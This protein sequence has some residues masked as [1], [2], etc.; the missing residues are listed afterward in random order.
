VTATVTQLKLHWP[1]REQHPSVRVNDPDTCVEPSEVRMSSG[2]LKAL[3][4]HYLH[5][6]GLT[7]FELADLTKTAQTSIGKRRGELAH[8][9][10]IVAT[11]DRRPSPSGAPSIVWKI[12][13]LGVAYVRALNELKGDK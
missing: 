1:N 5:A 12:T 7:D 10:L 13:P 9:G 3:G 4:A 8:D 11:T 6:S 2:R